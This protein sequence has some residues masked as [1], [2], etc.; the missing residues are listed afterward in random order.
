MTAHLRVA[1]F[2]EGSDERGARQAS[3]WLEVIWDGHLRQVS[4]C[5][6]F[7]KVVPIS[8]KDLIAM[9]PTGPRPTGS[10][11][12]DLKLRRLGAGREFDAAVVAW[13][14][15]PKW[16]GLD[17]FCRWDET[18]RLVERLAASPALPNA[19]RLAAEKRHAD[20][21]A[22]TEP[23]DRIGPRPLAAGDVF[24]LCMD[25]E[26]EDILTLEE[27]R[28]R[29]ALK[30]SSTPPG[31]PGGWG[32]GAARHPSQDVLGPAIS[33]AIRARSPLTRQIRG[34]WKTKKP[35]W[36]EYLLRTLLA[37][38]KGRAAI[39]NHPLVAR[40]TEARP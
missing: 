40:L 39:T 7:S 1:L 14:L 34:G 9:D 31:W 4:G 36:G 26:F 30:L 18:V 28:V 25:P 32:G 38:S 10:E 21:T 16:N 33:A 3:S 19:W 8:K 24:P 23:R 22:R 5:T 2:V 29:K 11:P 15:Y 12:L 37:D 27:R 13:D 20:Y 17:S 35:E 6:P